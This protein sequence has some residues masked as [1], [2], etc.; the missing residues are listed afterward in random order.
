M[1]YVEI[2]RTDI[3]TLLRYAKEEYQYLIYKKASDVPDGTPENDFWTLELTLEDAKNRITNETAAYGNI[4]DYQFA[5]CRIE[6]QTLTGWIS[7]AK[8]IPLKPRIT[9]NLI[10]VNI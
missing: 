5:C 3:D 6:R 10:N 1:A 9:F 2:P 4:P 7:K 8:G